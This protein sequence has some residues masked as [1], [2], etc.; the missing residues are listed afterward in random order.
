M[1][2][3]VAAIRDIPLPPAMAKLPVQNGYP[4]PWFVGWVNGEPDFRMIGPGKVFRAVKEKRCWLCGEPLGRLKASV[5][6]PMCAVNRITS[7]PPCHPLCAH[8]AVRACPF[9]SNPRMRRNTKDLPEEGQEAAGIH[10]DRN[11]GAMVLWMSLAFSRPFTPHL[12][13]PG[14]LF[15]LPPPHAVEWWM[16]GRRATREEAKEA[17]KAGLPALREVAAQEGEEAL[18]ALAEQVNRIWPLYPEE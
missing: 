4:V 14:V 10:I 1:T 5:I 12:G 2:D 18:Q 7:E 9:L 11:P 16:R 3:L 15:D 17:V 8:Y 6:G 13:N